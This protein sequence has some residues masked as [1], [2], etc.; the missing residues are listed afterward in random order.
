MIDLLL[1]TFFIIFFVGKSVSK[2]KIGTALALSALY[3]LSKGHLWP[4]IL[5][6]WSLVLPILMAILAIGSILYDITFMREKGKSYKIDYKPLKSLLIF[7]LIPGVLTTG[8]YFMYGDPLTW[9]FAFRIILSSLISFGGGEAYIAV[10]DTIFVQGGFISE[11]TYYSQIIGISSAMPGP[12]LMSIAAGIGFAYGSSTG[13]ML[14]GWVFGLLAISLAITAT[15]LGALFLLICFETF[16]DSHRLHMI[17]RYIMPL[18]CGMLI[19]I[20]LTLLNQSSGVLIREGV[21]PWLSVGFVIS[22]FFLMLLL[23]KKYQMNDIKLLLLGGLGTLISFSA[24]FN[25]PSV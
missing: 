23:R 2:I 25:G 9:D 7:L 21:N 20:A 6:E 11:T 16:K 10:A 8:A 18:I 3:A 14:L 12:V 17:I 24:I 19:S 4:P 1:M 15:A 13:G 22:L 5:D